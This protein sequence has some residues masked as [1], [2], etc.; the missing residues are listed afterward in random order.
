MKRFILGFF[1]A[2]SMAAPARAESV[3]AV[4]PIDGYK[5]MKLNLTEKQALDFSGASR[6]WILT[7]PQSHA[8][9]GVGASAVVLVRTPQHLVNG[10][11]EVL[12]NTGKPGW[13]EAD[14]VK[15]YDTNARCVPSLLSNGYYSG[16]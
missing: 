1:A 2:V 6:V 5:C 3:Y 14:K 9:H 8:P 11:L 15:P 10:Y 12:Q 13:I 7:A 16:G 4:H